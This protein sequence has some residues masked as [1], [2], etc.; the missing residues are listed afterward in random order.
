[1]VV[2][3]NS[4][5][6]IGAGVTTTVVVVTGMVKVVVETAVLV[7]VASSV[8]TVCGMVT[9]VV[10]ITVVVKGGKVTVATC[11]VTALVVVVDFAT[12]LFFFA[13][14]NITTATRITANTPTIAGTSHLF[15]C[16]FRTILADNFT[17]F[18]D[19]PQDN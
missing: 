10:E 19:N 8:I 12:V 4:V 18:L 14:A 1:M 6:V 16:I 2:V 17:R 11:V 9:V 3:T 5:V 7:T 15:F 13:P